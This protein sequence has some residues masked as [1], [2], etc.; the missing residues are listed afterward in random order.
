MKELVSVIIPVYNVQKYIDHCI[1]SVLTQT[2][3]NIEIIIVDDGSTDNSLKKSLMFSERDHRVKVFSQENAGVSGARNKGL[4]NAKGKY[5][6]FVDSDDTVSKVYVEQMVYNLEEKDADIS[7]SSYSHV[8]KLKEHMSD[9]KVETWSKKETLY[10]YIVKKKFV[11]GVC[12]K[13]YK[14][15]V[16]GDL[17]FKEKIRIAEDKLF[18][19]EAMK[20]SRRVVFQ[21]TPLYFYRVREMSAMHGDFDERYLE[22]KVVIDYLYEDWSSHY[23]QMES[24]FYKEKILSY[25]R[26]AQKS[27]GSN[28]DIAKKM[29]RIFLNEVKKSEIRKIIKYC[30]KKERIRI[31]CGKYFTFLLAG[32]EKGKNQYT[33]IK[34]A[35]IMKQKYND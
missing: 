35:G 10:N 15:D 27:F 25:A 1:Q 18:F 2:Y 3:K 4:A 33:R 11:P 20:R 6:C 34:K 26:Y 21:N 8:R 16:I 9:E 17:S 29:S 23:P 14:R 7:I 13:L 5:I 24:L 12:C 19:F 28:T 31:I 30:T 32:Y 22:S